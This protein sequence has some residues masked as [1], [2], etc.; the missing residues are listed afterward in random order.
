MKKWIDRLVDAVKDFFSPTPVPV[1][2]QVP[3]R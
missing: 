3:R 1:P 2:V